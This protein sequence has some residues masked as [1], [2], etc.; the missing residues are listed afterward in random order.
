MSKEYY[1]FTLIYKDDF[2][3]NSLNFIFGGGGGVK[4]GVFSYTFSDI[5]LI[6]RNS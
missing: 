2:L 4:E 5:L 3:K 1:L 6:L